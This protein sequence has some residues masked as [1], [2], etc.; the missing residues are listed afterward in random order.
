MTIRFHNSIVKAV[1]ESNFR[2]SDEEVVTLV[3]TKIKAGA[4]DDGIG[5]TYFG[6]LVGRTQ[7]KAYRGADQ[8]R[9]LEALAEAHKELMVLVNKG[10]ITPDVAANDKDDAE[11]KREKYAERQ[12]RTGFARSSASTLKRWI[13]GGGDIFA[14]D[15]KDA[16]KSTIQAEGKAMA[17][18]AAEEAGENT[19]EAKVAKRLASLLTA[20]SQLPESDLPAA[21]AHCC[22][23]IKAAR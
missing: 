9:V 1:T 18:E 14:L 7:D 19:P 13:V 21:I 10:A 4:V 20:L 22:A 2:P 8:E 5:D 3:Q 15:P 11:T 6:V 17:D 12:R 23:T 16:K